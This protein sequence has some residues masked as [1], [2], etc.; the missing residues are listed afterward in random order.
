M[1]LSKRDLLELG[2]ILLSPFDKEL[3]NPASIDIRVGD[4]FIREGGEITAFAEASEQECIVVN[5]SE[6]ILVATMERITVP[7]WLAID[8]RLKSSRAR[9][10]WN[11]ALAFWFDPGWT[12]IG[13]MELYNTN[14]FKSLVLRRGMKIAQIIVHELSSALGSMDVYKGKYKN[15]DTVEGSYYT[16][17]LSDRVVA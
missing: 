11:H 14:R 5:P 2:H 7:N 13:T 1:I 15:A 3:V 12:G 17:N 8:L 9:E 4:T 16:S 6:R 10:G